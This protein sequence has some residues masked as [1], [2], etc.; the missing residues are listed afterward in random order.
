MRQRP[1]NCGQT[2]AGVKP[3]M[4]W[5]PPSQSL[6]EG[7]SPGWECWQRGHGWK[8][9]VRSWGLS[10]LHKPWVSKDHHS[11]SDEQGAA[12]GETGSWGGG[13]RSLGKRR[14]GQCHP[15]QQGKCPGLRG[16]AERTWGDFCEGSKR[17]RPLMTH[18]S[19]SFPLPSG[20]RL[21]H[22]NESRAPSP[23]KRAR[24]FPNTH[25]RVGGLGVAG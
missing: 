22:S 16:A 20:E 10:N 19:G 2:E 7:Q 9:T 13:R 1:H 6:G 5:S 8:V 21:C 18:G 12:D 4:V 14:W 3:R 25:A 11:G 23:R 17:E 24:P 15:G